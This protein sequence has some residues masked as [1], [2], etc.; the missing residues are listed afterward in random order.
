MKKKLAKIKASFVF[1]VVAGFLALGLSTASAQTL[2]VYS[3]WPESFAVPIFEEFTAATGVKINFVRQSSGEVLAR[4]IA[5]KNNPRVGM[6]FGGPADTFAA[7]QRE[8]VLEPYFPE[9]VE[10]IPSQFRNPDGFYTGI[11]LNPIVFLSNKGFLADNGLEPASSWQ[12]LLDP[13]YKNQLQ[14]ADPRTSGTGFNRIASLIYA[15][16][17]EDAAFDYMKQLRENVQQYTK[18]GG[19]GTVPVGTRQA[20]AGIFFLVDSVE[21][22]ERGYDAVISFPQ[23]G[24]VVSVEAVALVKNGPNQDLA[25]QFIDWLV[26]PYVQGLYD[27]HSIGFMPTNPDAPLPESINVEGANFLDL[28]LEWAGENRQRLIEKWTEEVIG[29]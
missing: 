22:V 12:E 18:S 11:A 3:I 8:G 20:G 15:L 23:E 29:F 25:K 4:I 6:V 2:D 28:D 10:N 13:V 19:G 1:A 21:T 7:A 9:G 26:T 17:S 27:K 5:E 24:S 14:M 16:G